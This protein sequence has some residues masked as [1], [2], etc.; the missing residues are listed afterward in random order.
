[1]SNYVSLIMHCQ[2]PGAPHPQV[3]ARSQRPASLL[4]RHC[5]APAVDLQSL[6][7]ILAS[8]LRCSAVFWPHACDGSLVWVLLSGLRAV[9]TPL[10]ARLSVRSPPPGLPR[11]SP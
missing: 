11:W 3:A 5:S 8:R 2:L 4:R 9:W 10:T 1:V 6:R 7:S